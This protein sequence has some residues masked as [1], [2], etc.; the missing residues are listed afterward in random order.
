MSPHRSLTLI[1]FTLVV[2][3]AALSHTPVGRAGLAQATTGRVKGV[4]L[5]PNGAVIP[6]VK[7]TFEAEGLR[8][9]TTSNDRGEFEVEVPAGAYRVSAEQFGFLPYA[10]REL[11]VKA[12]KTRRV[13]V[14]FK[15]KGPCEVVT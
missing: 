14:V 2:A 1:A 6:G 3:L 10:R 9:E 11:R 12:G 15:C 5:D 7:V 13:K 4:V 8:R